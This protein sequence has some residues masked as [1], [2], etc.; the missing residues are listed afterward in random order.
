MNNIPPDFVVVV[1]P[2]SP[3]GTVIVTSSIPTVVV[4]VFTT[5]PD[6]NTVFCSALKLSA[7]ELLL[8]LYNYEKQG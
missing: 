6:I 8:D 5:L 3:T 4:P 1:E 7:S 2:G